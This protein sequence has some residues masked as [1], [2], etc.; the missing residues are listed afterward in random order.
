M[1][2]LGYCDFNN[3]MGLII[4]KLPSSY[5]CL[6][7]KSIKRMSHFLKICILRIKKILCCVLNDLKIKILFYFPYGYKKTAEL[8]SDFKSV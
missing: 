3:L 7:K 2:T 5:N 8:Y 1:R 6:L 4:K